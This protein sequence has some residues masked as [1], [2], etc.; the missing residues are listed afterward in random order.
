VVTD[1]EV[2]NMQ[3]SSRDRLNMRVWLMLAIAGT[4]LGLI[5]WYRYF[6]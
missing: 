1:Q 4:V 3:T 2:D 5:G 6:Q